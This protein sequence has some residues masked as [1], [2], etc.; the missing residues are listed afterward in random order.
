MQRTLFSST[1]VPTALVLLALL[2][3]TGPASAGARFVRSDFNGDGR[4]DL[5]DPISILEYLFLAQGNP[6]CLDAG[7]I[8]DDG[9]LD[10]S[11]VIYALVF[12]FQGGAAPPHPYPDCGDDPTLD[13]LDCQES[14]CPARAPNIS[15]VLGDCGGVPDDEYPNSLK[16]GSGLHKVTLEALRA[17]C[18]DGT[19]AVIYV[20][21]AP[22]ESANASK[23]VIYLQG[24]GGCTTPR[25]CAERWCSRNTN[26]DASK[27]SS[28]YTPESIAATGIFRRSED[29]QFGDFNQVY[30]YYCSSDSWSGQQAEPVL[31]LP[32]VPGGEFS[33]HFKGHDI[34]DEGFDLLLAGGLT[35]DD[36]EVELPP[37]DSADFA[38][39]TGFSAGSSGV[40]I[41]GDFLASKLEPQGTEVRLVFDAAFLPLAESHPD[42][43][44]VPVV[45][46]LLMERALLSREIVGAPGFR[47]GFVDESAREH[48]EG[49][50]DEWKLGSNTHVVLDHVTTPFFLSID[51][52]DSKVRDFLV[53]GGVD[54]EDV[55]RMMQWT[56]ENLGRLVSRSTE[57]SDIEQAPGARGTLCG[58]HVGLNSNAYFFERTVED[59]D[60]IPR[61]YHDALVAW[62]RGH[63]VAISDDPD[64]PTTVCGPPEE[65]L[66]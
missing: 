33:I 29:N 43:A 49:T 36:G 12:G 6:G 55:P 14:P 27:M 40:Q 45:R 48:L 50:E 34:L 13:E 53:E 30:F 31:S 56:L 65:E 28:L 52:S 38:L 22:P 37:L 23:W 35:S 10:I 15:D 9:Q 19:P 42:P 26:Y 39:I 41:N 21:A 51:I 66:E 59:I 11:D 60:G 2:L 20:R 8:N 62:L 3:V 32:E 1:A 44:M 54:E 63:S 17:V 58:T 25:G 57:V 4:S 61:T 7:D 24:G 47:N 16:P 18:N 46:E 64:H 5:T